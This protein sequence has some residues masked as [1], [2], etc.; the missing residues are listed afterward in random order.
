MRTAHVY[1]VF[2]VGVENVLKLNWG[3]GCSTLLIY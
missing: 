3:D 2:T 1:M